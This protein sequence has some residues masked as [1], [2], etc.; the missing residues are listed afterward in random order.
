ML[1]EA[2]MARRRRAVERGNPKVGGSCHAQ[3]R[4]AAA[5]D[6]RHHP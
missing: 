3:Q 1:V 4:G 6:R 5:P 2:A